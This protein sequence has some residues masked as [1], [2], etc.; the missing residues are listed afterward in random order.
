M[1]PALM[2]SLQSCQ[3]A[4]RKRR[5]DLY[6]YAIRTNVFLKGG[7]RGPRSKLPPH[8]ARLM[9][10]ANL[11]YASQ[12]FQRA[13]ELLHEV[14]KQNPNVSDPYHTLGLIH[15]EM[16][17]NEKAAQFFMIAAHL[18]RKDA[19]LWRRVAILSKVLFQRVLV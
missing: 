1:V 16:G 12:E 9:G 5:Y 7:K 18:T 3:L 10:E 19:S 15:E 6:E 11:A 17:Q 2:K 4:K 8:L 14:V 13:I